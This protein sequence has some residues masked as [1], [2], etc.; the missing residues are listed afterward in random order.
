[1]MR[2]ISFIGPFS[3]IRIN[4]ERKKNGRQR[5]RNR[6]VRNLG[7]QIGFSGKSVFYAGGVTKEETMRKLILIALAGAAIGFAVPQSASATP[8]G[9]GLGAA[10]DTVSNTEQVRHRRWHHHRWHHRHWHHRHCWH[11]RH[12]SGRRCW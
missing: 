1:M 9:I 3:A 5:F 4:K 7:V 2:K 11:R 12:W 10:A 6:P 8:I